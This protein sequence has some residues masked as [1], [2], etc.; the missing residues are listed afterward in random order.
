MKL[1]L[2]KKQLKNLSKDHKVLPMDLTA[3]IAGG[4]RAISTSH[5]DYCE[6]GLSRTETG[7][8]HCTV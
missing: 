1:K 6:R 8:T 7:P 2:N 5:P 4:K 3:E